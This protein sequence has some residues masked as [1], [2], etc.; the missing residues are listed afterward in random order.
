M[1]IQIKRRMSFWYKSYYYIANNLPV[2]VVDPKKPTDP[3][4]TVR[5]S[6][7]FV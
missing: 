7:E 2:G 3:T 1:A 6:L 5:N 4:F